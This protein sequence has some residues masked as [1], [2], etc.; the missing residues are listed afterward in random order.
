M[1]PAAKASYI[2]NRCC[3]QFPRDQLQAGF[4]W[5]EEIAEAGN[6]RVEEIASAGFDR[7]DWKRVIN[8]CMEFQNLQY[9]CVH[10]QNII[11]AC[12]KLEGE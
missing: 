9:S 12:S 4:G 6:G 3:T 11:N 1:S 7:V 10:L 5:I 2:I 8:I